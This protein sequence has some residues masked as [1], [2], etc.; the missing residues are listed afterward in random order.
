MNRIKIMLLLAVLITGGQR[1]GAFG[2][3]V[4][5]FS[6]TDVGM[7]ITHKGYPDN[8][9]TTF[10]QIAIDTTSG[11]PGIMVDNQ[12][13]TI[14]DT[15][16]ATAYN[17]VD[18]FI[19]TFRIGSL[20]RFYRVDKNG[21]IDTLTAVA[22][23]HTP[24]G[25]AYKGACCNSNGIL[26][27]T[28]NGASDGYIYYIDLNTPNANG[29]F[30]TFAMQLPAPSTGAA[31]TGLPDIVWNPKNNTIYGVEGATSGGSPTADAGKVVVIA[32]NAD[33]KSIA[34][35]SR[36]GTHV[37]T[38]YSYAGV[39]IVYPS[40][41][42]ANGR[43]YGVSN[44]DASIWD[45]DIS[46]GP[47]AGAKRRLTTANPIAANDGLSCPALWS[48][49]GV[50]K[51]DGLISFAPGELV[52]YTVTV[53]N[54]GPAPVYNMNIVDTVPLFGAGTALGW[55]GTQHLYNGVNSFGVIS[56]PNASQDAIRPVPKTNYVINDFITLQVGDTIT[57]RFN[58]AFTQGYTS[59]KTFT[60]KV[61]AIPDNFTIDPVMSN[62]MDYDTDQVTPPILPVNPSVRIKMHK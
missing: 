16:N 7:I 28:S 11:T 38:Y 59:G 42:D 9:H 61:W 62:N 56:G 34:S 51:D 20:T 47:S 21:Q 45:F 54:N 27:L 57:Y 26:Y 1:F 55:S 41:S 14:P 25:S 8:K 39:F 5:P 2:K 4:T 31:T 32:L 22:P 10:S 53:V 13:F 17:P 12:L 30:Q 23:S 24:Q 40:G 58:L 50:A 3:A 43:M 15:I 6:C 29:N 44:D 46:Q 35:F 48:D 18:G 49:V 52:P 19:Y 60:N 36:I 33:G 37:T